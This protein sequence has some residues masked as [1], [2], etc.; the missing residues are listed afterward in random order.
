MVDNNNDGLVYPVPDST[1]EI[2][3]RTIDGIQKIIRPHESNEGQTPQ[4]PVIQINPAM[5][6]HWESEIK[7]LRE[8][9]RDPEKLREILKIKQREYE[10]A[11]DREDI[12]GLVSEIEMLKFVLFMACR[13]STICNFYIML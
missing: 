2:I 7:I 12:E 8:A 5:K 1:D 10:K 3:Q 13:N 9:P 11:E 6:R 4:V